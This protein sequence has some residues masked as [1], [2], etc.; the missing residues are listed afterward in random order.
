MNRGAR[1]RRAGQRGVALITA[2][3]ITALASMLAVSLVARQQVEIRR[4]ANVLEN[5]RAYLFA[6]GAE[7]WVK[8]I[9]ARDDRQ[10]DSLDEDWALT[11][12]PLTVEGAQLAGRVEDMQARFNLNNLVR[13]GKVSEPDLQIFQR[14]L[15]SF[16][17]NPDL[18]FAVVDW[19]D[20]DMDPTYPGGAE[21]DEYLSKEVPYRAANR[22]MVSPSELLLVKDFTPDLYYQLAPYVT[23]LPVPTA[24]NVNTASAVV[25]A[26][27]A[28]GLSPADMEALV[29]QRKETS[30][31]NAQQFLQFG[32]L[33][34][35]GAAVPLT[36]LAVTSDFFMLQ[37]AARFG[38]RGK[39]DLYSL[40]S[41]KANKVAVL[42]RAQGVY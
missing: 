38:D 10:K 24:I 8:H 34:D 35:A 11:L 1:P 15:Q 22:P 39:V 5:E 31:D 13:G 4:T 2:I 28:D 3:L 17:A 7:S 18:A 6:L 16:G 36:S 26:A 20:E 29:E 27:V 12:P 9:L 37:A 30:F 25:L 41:R 42:W 33:R 14:L 19:I 23:A 21:D 40:F 32:A